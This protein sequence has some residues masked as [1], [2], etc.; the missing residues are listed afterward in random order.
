MGHFG[1]TVAGEIDNLVC[2]AIFGKQQ[3][4]SSIEAIVSA[5]VGRCG[6]FI[7]KHAALAGFEKSR[8]L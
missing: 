3:R 2:L 8:G 6:H 1:Y 4:T 5:I 7:E